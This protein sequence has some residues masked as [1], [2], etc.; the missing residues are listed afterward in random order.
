MN[1]QERLETAVTAALLAR[2]RSLDWLSTALTAVAAALLLAGLGAAKL[3]AAIVLVG[4]GAKYLAGRVALDARLFEIVAERSLATESFDAAMTRL[5]LLP[6][7]KTGRPWADRC[8][9]ATRL[10]RLQA[11]TV[12]LQCMLAVGAAF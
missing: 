2:G 3:E 10:F 12:A 5:G 4:I 1:D 6:S 9:G 11:V 8:R 7:A